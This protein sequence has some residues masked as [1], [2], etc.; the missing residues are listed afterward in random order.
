MLDEANHKSRTFKSPDLKGLLWRCESE[1]AAMPLEL[2]IQQ[3]VGGLS[4]FPRGEDKSP[5]RPNSDSLPDEG[6]IT[7]DWNPWSPWDASP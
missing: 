6:E 5:K 7:D 1:G 3:Q 2:L 4:D